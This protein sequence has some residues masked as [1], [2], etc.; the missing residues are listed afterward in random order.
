MQGRRRE[1]FACG[2]IGRIVG[3]CGGDRGRLGCCGWR[4]GC[5]ERL[6]RLRSARAAEVGAGHEV[7]VGV[8]GLAWGVPAWGEGRGGGVSHCQSVVQDIFSFEGLLDELFYT[9]RFTPCKL[10]RLSYFCFR[11]YSP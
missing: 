5:Q 10:F 4:Y 9:L 8:Q 3:V 7:G 2:R 11:S 1:I 6:G